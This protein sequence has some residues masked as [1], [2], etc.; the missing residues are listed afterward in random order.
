MMRTS[1]PYVTWM[2]CY[3]RRIT[4]YTKSTSGYAS[5][6][7]QTIGYARSS[8]GYTSTN[9]NEGPV[10]RNHAK[11]LQQEVHAFISELHCNI[12]ES[13]ILPKSCTLLL[14]RFTQE[15]SPLGYVKDAK[16]YIEDPNTT[17]QVEKGYTHK[18][19][20]YTVEAPTSC[21][22][23]YHL[24]KRWGQAIHSW[25]HLEVKI[26]TQQITHHFTEYCAEAERTRE[27]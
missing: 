16:G 4:G 7:K 14:L 17:A 3:T 8:I 11:K 20:G 2:L 26:P 22:S 1:Q 6:I 25:K 12:D 21:P 23:L 27:N 5:R 24:G 15:A 18:T 10:T 19:Q 9:M 13:H